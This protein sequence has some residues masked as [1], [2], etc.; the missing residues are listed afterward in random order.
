VIGIHNVLADVMHED[1]ALE[2]IV[3]NNIPLYLR[4]QIEHNT[5]SML[6]SQRIALMKLNAS[7]VFHLSHQPLL[8]QSGLPNQLTSTPKAANQATIMIKSQT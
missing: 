5:R 4:R 3:S 8:L 6:P 7:A 2:N 1:E